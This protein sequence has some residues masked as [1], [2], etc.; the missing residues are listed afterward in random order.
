[1]KETA[2]LP[3]ALFNG[4]VATT[5]GVYSIKDIDIESAKEFVAQYGYISAIGHEATADIMSD[6]FGQTIPMNR[7][8]F[9]QQVGQKAIALKLNQR[10]PEGYILNRQEVEKIGFT[11]KLIERLA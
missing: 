2:K 8:Q 5:D 6:L 4:T 9:H 11:V 3:V 10:P 7:I 1:M